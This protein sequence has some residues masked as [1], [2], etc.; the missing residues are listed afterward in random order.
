MD[1]LPLCYV[2]NLYGPRIPMF[3]DMHTII[4]IKSEDA[5]CMSFDGQRKSLIM[6]RFIYS[7]A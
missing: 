2:T 5:D 7:N 4:R 3:H 6:K 1:H